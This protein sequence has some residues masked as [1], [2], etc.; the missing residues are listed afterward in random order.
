MPT[1]P[2]AT[3][4]PIS[5]FSIFGH[6][7]TLCREAQGGGVT[8]PTPWSSDKL[9]VVDDTISCVSPVG[10]IF[11][12]MPPMG[13]FCTRTPGQEAGSEGGPCL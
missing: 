12:P 3:Q 8:Q 1:T 4:A 7:S 10:V 2:P 11:Y 9:L 6:G 5:P 13:S